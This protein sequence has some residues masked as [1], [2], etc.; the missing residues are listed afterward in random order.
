MNEI[1]EINK[2]TLPSEIL[3]KAFNE[4]CKELWKYTVNKPLETSKWEMYQYSEECDT[5]ISYAMINNGR[6][7][8]SFREEPI[9]ESEHTRWHKERFMME[10]INKSCMNI[11]ET[12]ITIVQIMSTSNDLRKYWKLR[13]IAWSNVVNLQQVVDRIIDYVVGEPQLVKYRKRFG[14]YVWKPVK[15]TTDKYSR[16]S[17]ILL[18]NHKYREKH[19]NKIV[20]KES[21]KIRY[22]CGLCHKEVDNEI[23]KENNTFPRRILDYEHTTKQGIIDIQTVTYRVTEEI[24]I[25]YWTCNNNKCYKHC[26]NNFNHCNKG[27]YF[28]KEI[29]T[30]QEYIE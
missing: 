27:K 11:I 15:Y 12:Y 29:I 3:I 10:R 23:D 7:P 19:Y 20:R 21:L 22:R 2:K 18:I 9:F 6:S 13:R 4:K 16:A 26:L 25:V 5:C 1:Q 24:K 17:N 8:F 14:T 28:T 30:P